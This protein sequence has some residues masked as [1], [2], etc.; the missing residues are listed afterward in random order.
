[1]YQ[2]IQFYILHI[3][4]FYILRLE[5]HLAAHIDFFIS[6]KDKYKNNENF[7]NNI[8]LQKIL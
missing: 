1:M 4:K 5:T 6:F 3:I 7:G 8:N 2:I